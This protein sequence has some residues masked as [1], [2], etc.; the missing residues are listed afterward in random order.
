MDH[1]A[2]ILDGAQHSVSTVIHLS[3][4]GS[5]IRHKDMKE[6]LHNGK[7]YDGAIFVHALSSLDAILPGTTKLPITLGWWSKSK[8]AAF[9]FVRLM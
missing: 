7:L 2:V 6:K 4:I 9:W 5:L 8:S 1:F 3:T